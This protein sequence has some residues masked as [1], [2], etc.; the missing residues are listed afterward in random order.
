MN[1]SRQNTLQRLYTS[2][3]LVAVT[4]CFCFFASSLQAQNV[5]CSVANKVYS[6]AGQKGKAHVLVTNGIDKRSKQYLSR[7][8]LKGLPAQ[9]SSS[10][11]PHLWNTKTQT[12]SPL[13]YQQET[14][15]EWMILP[16]TSQKSMENS[17]ATSTLWVAASATP[18]H[19]LFGEKPLWKISLECGARTVLQELLL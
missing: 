14:N 18:S 17:T 2:R 15:L 16:S 4:T 3:L 8:L 11:S 13:T 12:T 5:S 10:L 1:L 9:N 19:D 6:V 7:S